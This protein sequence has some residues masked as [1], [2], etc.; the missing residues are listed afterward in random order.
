MKKGNLYVLGGCIVLLAGVL[1]A[2]INAEFQRKEL[3]IKAQTGAV[4]VSCEFAD[5]KRT[6]SQTMIQDFVDGVWYFTN[7][8][9]RSC[10]VKAND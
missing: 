5:G 1:V 3:V 7:G 6:V 10:E 9:A 4:E 2:G 8:H